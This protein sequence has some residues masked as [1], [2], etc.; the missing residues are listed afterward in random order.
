MNF[1]GRGEFDGDMTGPMRRPRVEG[2]FSGE[3]MR[4]WDTNWGTGDAH[5]TVEN[6][7]LTV[8]DGVIRDGDSEIRAEG[9]FSLGYPRAGTAAG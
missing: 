2:R 4:A 8:G 7:Y 1:G 6:S 5:I 3:D 9:L